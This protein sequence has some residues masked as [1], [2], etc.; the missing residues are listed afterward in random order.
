MSYIPILPNEIIN[1]IL[2]THKGFSNKTAILLNEFIDKDT[3][4]KYQHE[5]IV[6]FFQHLKDI[7]FLHDVKWYRHPHIWYFNVAD[8]DSDEDYYL[9][10]YLSD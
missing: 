2:F 1:K 4:Y 5:P 8:I 6:N 3:L 10:Y 7:H 9:D